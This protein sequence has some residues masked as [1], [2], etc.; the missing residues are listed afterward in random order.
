MTN[1]KFFKDIILENASKCQSIAVIRNAPADNCIKTCSLSNC[2]D[3]IFDSYEEEDKP[4]IQ[5]RYEWLYKEHEETPTLTK[6]EWH[7]LE[8]LQHGEIYRDTLGNIFWQPSENETEY[9]LTYELHKGLF[10]F[11]DPNY[12]RFSVEKML[13]WE[14]EGN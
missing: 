5:K 14:I 1:F 13:T 2:K 6:R 9:M 7:F 11:C 3:C 12:T 10:G 8:V 4:C